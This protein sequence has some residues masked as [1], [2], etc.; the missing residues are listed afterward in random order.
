MQTEGETE[1]QAQGETEVHN[2]GSENYRLVVKPGRSPTTS[3]RSARTRREE[4]GIGTWTSQL[5]E[6]LPEQSNHQAG[7]DR[8]KDRHGGINSIN[9]FQLLKFLP[10]PTCN[11]TPTLPSAHAIDPHLQP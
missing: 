11:R 7:N 8:Q 2:V 10:H 3:K 6:Q 9:G 5:N 4:S 1:V